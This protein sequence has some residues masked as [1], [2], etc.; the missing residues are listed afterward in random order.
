ML[1]ADPV[2]RTREPR[3][4]IGEDEMADRQEFFGDFGIAAFGDGVMIIAALA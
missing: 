2:M 3:L 4:E 1:C